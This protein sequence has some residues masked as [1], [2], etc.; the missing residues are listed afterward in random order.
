MS[1]LLEQGGALR[2]VHGVNSRE[3]MQRFLADQRI[4]AFEADVSWGFL[5]GAPGLLLPIM[6]HRQGFRVKE[7]QV[8]HREEVGK[9]GFFGVGVYLRR[10]LD[11]LAVT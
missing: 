10:L 2:F 6:A 1:R 3:R 9:R 11:I 5:R 4:N 8:V 7:V